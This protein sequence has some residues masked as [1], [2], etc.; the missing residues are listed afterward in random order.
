MALGD[1][2]FSKAMSDFSMLLELHGIT[3][4][5]TRTVQ[6]DIKEKDIFGTPQNY[7][8]Q[9][10]AVKF[11]VTDQYLDETSIIA[12]GKPKEVIKLIAVPSTF[13]ENDEIPYNSHTYQVT[14]VGKTVLGSNNSLEMYTATRQVE[15]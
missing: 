14:D 13:I 10:L 15:T 6:E 7:I 3:A 4:T 12:G 11:L 2:R 5:I 9:T 8:P 1:N